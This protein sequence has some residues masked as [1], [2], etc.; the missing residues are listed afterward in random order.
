MEQLPQELHNIIF[1]YLSGSDKILY[2][3]YLDSI[4]PFNFRYKKCITYKD[5]FNLF[6]LKSNTKI[7]LDVIALFKFTTPD[8]ISCYIHNYDNEIIF[9]RMLHIVNPNIY[10]IKKHFIHCIFKCNK[11]LF[12]VIHSKYQEHYD[13]S[14]NSESKSKIYEMIE[15]VKCYK[16]IKNYQSCI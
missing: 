8:L 9:R 1:N 15:S 5:T 4:L 11:N 3:L 7:I 2:I 12:K 13:S 14:W 16:C 10:E 6:Y